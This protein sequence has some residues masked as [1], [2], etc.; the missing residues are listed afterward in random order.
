MGEAL[1]DEIKQDLLR[2]C[3]KPNEPDT[4]IAEMVVSLEEMNLGSD[5]EDCRD[6]VEALYLDDSAGNFEYHDNE[7][8]SD[9]DSESEFDENEESGNI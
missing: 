9:K 2:Q 5:D 8:Y 3:F 6:P 7:M 4:E 1:S